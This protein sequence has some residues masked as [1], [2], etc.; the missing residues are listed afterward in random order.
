MASKQRDDI[1]DLSPLLQRDDCKGASSASFPIDGEELRVGLWASQIVSGCSLRALGLI[2]N[3]ELAGR[4]DLDQI[5]VPCISAN[6]DVVIA[7]LL[8]RGF[9][10]NMPWIRRSDELAASDEAR[11]RHTVLGR[12][13]KATG[14]V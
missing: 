6:A 2:F 10:E 5:R 3:L 8:P 7:E 1:R 9:T 14:H 4:T 11:Q 12:S 13:N